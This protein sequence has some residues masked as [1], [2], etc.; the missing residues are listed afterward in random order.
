MPAGARAAG[1]A[2]LILAACTDGPGRPPVYTDASVTPEAGVEDTGPADAGEP[3]DSGP[4]DVL[5]VLPDSG[6]LPEYA[7]TGQFGI[8]NDS[9]P[10]FARE[11]Q[12]Y[13]QLVVAGL[14]YDYVGTID[15][16]G[17]V[18]VVSTELAG[19]GCPEPRITGRYTRTD[20]T[21]ELLHKTCNAAGDPVSS[22]IRGGFFQDFN[23]AVSGT[24][25]V[26]MAVT[27]DLAN[28]FGLGPVGGRAY[29]GLSVAADR[30]VSLF[31]AA[32][33]VGPPAAYFGRFTSQDLSAFSAIHHLD[34]TNDGPQVA[35]QAQLSQPTANDPVQIAGTRDVYLPETG[36][37]IS[38]EF[39]GVRVDAP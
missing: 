4:Q 5:V 35:M 19:S 12:G 1:L 38:V 7:F 9:N 23:P 20:T 31:V 28:C 6:P 11:V 18:A 15:A 24:Y 30:T 29:W 3:E 13:L 34:A 17:N 8:L 32:D 16:D 37:T 39:S 25:E 33:P 21:F 36:C 10:L 26:T 2:A 14:P 27:R 22:T